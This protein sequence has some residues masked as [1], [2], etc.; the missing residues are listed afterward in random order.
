[1]LEWTQRGTSGPS[2]H[3]IG[4]HTGHSVW[5]SVKTFSVFFESLHKVQIKIILRPHQTTF[6]PTSASPCRLKASRFLKIRLPEQEEGERPLWSEEPAWLPPH[7][8]LLMKLYENRSSSPAFTYDIFLWMG[9]VSV[10]VYVR[11]QS[12]QEDRGGQVERDLCWISNSE[13]IWQVTLCSLLGVVL[14]QRPTATE[15]Q[16][17][18]CREG[19][20]ECSLSHAVKERTVCLCVRDHFQAR[21]EV[22]FAKFVFWWLKCWAC[23][24]MHASDMCVHSWYYRETQCIWTFAGFWDTLCMCTWCGLPVFARRAC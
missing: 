9:R 3:Q 15:T 23:L 7:S 11:E 8:F 5:V 24:Q 20:H 14:R 4:I 1:M 12:R 6:L 18:T 17:T 16:Q 13:S 2:D 21:T 19:N 22:R 10:S